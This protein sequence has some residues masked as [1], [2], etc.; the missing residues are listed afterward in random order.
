MARTAR[1]N[2]R[3]QILQAAEKRLWHFGYKKTTI[4]EIAADAGVAKG[5]VY[6]HF[7]SK[8]DIYC[9][10]VG[11]FKGQVLSEQEEVA[12]A[13]N[14]TALE[15]LRHMLKLPVAT[16]Y[17]VCARSPQAMEMIVAI[18]PQLK[19]RLQSLIERETQLITQI[20]EEGVQSGEFASVEPEKTAQTLKLMTMAFLPPDTHLRT[21]D[22][23]EDELDRIIDLAYHGLKKRE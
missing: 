6:L 20:V 12:R 4:D 15:K 21:A 23:L 11:Q 5:T 14:L 10:I 16:A 7:E 18:R 13:T 1:E 3:E 17:S 2:V 19:D 8:E 22:D 9:A